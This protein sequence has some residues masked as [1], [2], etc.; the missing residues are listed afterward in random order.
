MKYLLFDTCFWF[1]LL[2]PQDSD[3]QKAEQMFKEFVNSEV[4]ILVP[5]PT[6]YETLNTEFVDNKMILYEFNRI[7]SDKEHVILVDDEKYKDN[8]YDKTIRQHKDTKVSLV[9]NIIME[10]ARAN[11]IKVDG[12]VSFNER[13]FGPFCKERQMTL[14][15]YPGMVE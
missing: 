2:C 4:R 14:F 10:I 7:L 8:A 13:D 5:Y 11:E 15:C 3:H 1:G 6:L 9:D 12:I